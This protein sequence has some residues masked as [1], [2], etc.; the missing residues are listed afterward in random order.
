VNY[1]M[2]VSE[3]ASRSSQDKIGRW[4][5]PDKWTKSNCHSNLS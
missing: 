1:H 3:G 5:S 2:Q 4:G